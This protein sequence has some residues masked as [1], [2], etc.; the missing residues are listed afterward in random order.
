M[1]KGMI[2]LEYKYDVQSTQQFKLQFLSAQR[3]TRALL[4]RNLDLFHSIISIEPRLYNRTCPSAREW[5]FGLL[6][7]A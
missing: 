2:Q 1:A 3:K 5:F 6:L 4:D 7:F